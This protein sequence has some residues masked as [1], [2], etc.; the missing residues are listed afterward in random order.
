M[1][2]L[3]LVDIEDDAKIQTVMT[4][5]VVGDMAVH[6]TVEHTEITLPTPEEIDKAAIDFCNT[7]IEMP[8]CGDLTYETEIHSAG[9][10]WLLK[11]ITDETY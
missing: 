4:Y 1:K 9:A 6:G 11:K 10:N 7:E 2:K 8:E 3:L 5:R